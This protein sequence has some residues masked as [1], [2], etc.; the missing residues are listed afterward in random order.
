MH[1]YETTTKN[2]EEVNKHVYSMTDIARWFS[3]DD[4]FASIVSNDV[5]F[6]KFKTS[7][8]RRVLLLFS[9]IKIEKLHII[10]LGIKQYFYM[11]YNVLCLC[12]V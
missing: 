3:S 6:D 2:E 4:G 7:Y 12:G 5:F 8:S 11:Y 10:I 1:V 9:I